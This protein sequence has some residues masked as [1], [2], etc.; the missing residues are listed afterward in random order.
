MNNARAKLP[1]GTGDAASPLFLRIFLLMLVCVAVVQ[2][3]NFA[4]LVAVQPPTPR[5]Y[6][7]GEIARVLKEGRDPSGQLVFTEHQQIDRSILAPRAERARPALAMAL[8]VPPDQ[9]D[10]G[11][12]RPPFPQRAPTYERNALPRAQPPRDIAAARAFIV[13]DAFVASYKR[14][15]GSWVTI[16]PAS[17]EFELWR[18]FGLL[19]LLFT[20]LAVVPFAWALAHRLAKPIRAFAAAAERLGRDPRASPM[21]LS[22]PAE[23]ADAAASFN[24][25]QARLNRYVDDRTTMIGAL[26]HD[27]RTPLMRLELRLERAPVALR[28]SCESDIRDMEAMVAATLAYV[29][30]MSLPVGRRPLDLRSLT[31]SVT[32]DLADR[33]AAVSLEPGDPMVIDGHSAAL[34]TMLSNLISNAVKYAGGAQVRLGREPGEVRIEVRDEGPGIP[35]E[36]LDRVFEPLFRGERSRNRD[37]GGMGLGLASAR[38]VARAHGGEIILQNRPEGGLQALVTLPV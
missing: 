5:A 7:M 8:E 2:L 6:T 37:T 30:D 28:Q 20:A 17:R 4:L 38:A 35:A 22:G 33:G 34:K 13:L 18:W 32:D 1:W 31:E 15:D 19:W 12:E 3:L 26:A 23:I 27:L 16:R 10:F 36:D 9:S 21:A 25:M 24:K 29:R 14:P 11:F